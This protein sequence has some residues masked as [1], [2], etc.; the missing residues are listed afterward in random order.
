MCFLSFPKDLLICPRKSHY[1]KIKRCRLK[2]YADSY[3]VDRN[4][5]SDF[6]LYLEIAMITKIVFTQL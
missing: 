1:A 3:S 6:Q 5:Q 2:T 4:L